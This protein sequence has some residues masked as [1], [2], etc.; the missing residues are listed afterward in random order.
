MVTSV[1]GSLPTSPASPAIDPARASA[2]SLE[3]REAPAQADVAATGHD[4]DR[5]AA[6]LLK[7]A[8]YDDGAMP[9]GPEPA[10]AGLLG[11]TT[12]A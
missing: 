2:S 7:P 8:H 4:G 12:T 10:I 5:A 3:G 6:Y 11:R 1:S 9:D